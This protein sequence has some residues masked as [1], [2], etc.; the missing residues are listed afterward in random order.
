M[1]VSANVDRGGA[2]LVVARK[3]RAENK[4]EDGRERRIGKGRRNEE[5]KE[6]V[7]ESITAIGDSAAGDNLVATT[8]AEDGGGRGL[9]KRNSNIGVSIRV[10][11]Y[12]NCRKFM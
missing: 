5:K 9:K 4:E 2:R 11:V 8:S 1:A 6:M 10:H 3:E 12:L 7:V